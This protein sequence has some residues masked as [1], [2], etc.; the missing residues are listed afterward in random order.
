MSSRFYCWKKGRE[1]LKVWGIYVRIPF[2]KNGVI[3]E[4][5][6]HREK[7]RGIN[8]R[9]SNVSRK[10]P[11]SIEYI[12]ICVLLARWCYPDTNNG[13]IQSELRTTK[14]PSGIFRSLPPH[15]KREAPVVIIEATQK[16]CTVSPYL[17]REEIGL[18]VCQHDPSLVSGDVTAAEVSFCWCFF[19]APRSLLS[20][21][22]KGEEEFLEF[23]RRTS[24]YLKREVLS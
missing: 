21:T 9:G 17:P 3:R 23:F 1:S 24:T 13:L 2:G 19:V 14:L 22:D 12:D 10:H 4:W 18:Y 7:G 6:H 20:G 15:P 11:L 8:Q 16:I 5:E